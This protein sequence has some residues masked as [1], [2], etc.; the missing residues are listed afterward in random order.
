MPR[1]ESKFSWDTVIMAA[2]LLFSGVGAYALVI[3]RQVRTET[4]VVTLSATDTRIE[5]TMQDNS[6]IFRNELSEFRQEFREALRDL[7]QD[8]RRSK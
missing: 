7:R 1:F 8:I 5:K 6:D 3:E 2:V 4:A